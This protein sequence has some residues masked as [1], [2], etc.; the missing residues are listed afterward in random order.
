MILAVG[1]AG[2]FLAQHEYQ[3]EVNL[4]EDETKRETITAS[5]G[6]N[7]TF[8]SLTSLSTVTI[9]FSEDYAPPPFGTLF[10]L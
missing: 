4:D 10:R 1:N 7:K 5:S 2:R 3:K 9:Q 6:S 8:G